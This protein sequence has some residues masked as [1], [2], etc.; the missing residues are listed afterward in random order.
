MITL[1]ESELN[2]AQKSKEI[3]TLKLKLIIAYGVF[4]M[5]VA[6]EIVRVAL[7]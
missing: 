1:N 7:W 4:L 6:L 2:E 5:M 3:E